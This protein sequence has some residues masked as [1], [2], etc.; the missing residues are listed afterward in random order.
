LSFSNVGFPAAFAEAFFGLYLGIVSR[1][2]R[3]KNHPNAAF[4]RSSRASSSSRKR[5]ALSRKCSRLG[6]ARFEELFNDA[7]GD[8]ILFFWSIKFFP[9]SPFFSLASTHTKHT[10]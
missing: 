8:G 9:I 7:S 3:I 5:S 1:S 10:R 6:S 2:A 4:G